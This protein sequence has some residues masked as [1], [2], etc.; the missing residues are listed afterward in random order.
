M[1]TDAKGGPYT[2]R[3]SSV[4]DSFTVEDAAERIVAGFSKSM[5]QYALD[6]RDRL[7]AAYAAGRA[8]VAGECLA[9]MEAAVSA[10]ESPPRFRVDQPTI[11][12][13]RSAI[14]ALRGTT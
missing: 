11:N 10:M 13:L 3:Y 9:A 12:Q 14:A 5:E 1:T 2:V 4:L 8:S 6:E 7:N